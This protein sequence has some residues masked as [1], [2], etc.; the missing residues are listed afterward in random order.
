MTE[1][2]TNAWYVRHGPA[3]AHVRWHVTC[4]HGP[5]YPDGAVLDERDGPLEV[6]DALR[7]WTAGTDD[8]QR[9]RL[10]VN[11]AAVPR[12]PATWF[13]LLDERR[14]DPAAMVLVAF[15]TDD[16]PDGTV[17]DNAAFMAL[18][19]RNDQQVAAVQWSPDTAIVRQVFVQPDWRRRQLA[20]KMVYAASAYHQAQG[21]AGALH[22]DGRRTDLGEEF[23]AGLRHPDRIARWKERAEPMD[24]A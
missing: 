5:Q 1:A 18:S 12:S 19:V 3:T 9:L 2:A 17:I 10:A 8:A 11:H 14:H 21:W 20:T 22:S 7:L 16:L 13:T 24:P 6:G 15:A 23:T 4:Y